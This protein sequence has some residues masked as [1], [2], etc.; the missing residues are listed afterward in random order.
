MTD[1]KID[2]WNP[3]TEAKIDEVKAFTREEVADAVERAQRAQREWVALS[4]AARQQLL[5]DIA[6]TVMRHRDE[7]A[8]LESQDVGKP[9]RAALAEA[10]SVA[11]VFRY[12]AG[13][14]DKLSGESIPVDGGVTLTFHEPVGVVG[15]I[16]PWNFPLPIASWN[17]APALA[18]GN[19]VIV[20]PASLTPLS[21]RRLGELVE[22]ISP[23]PGLLQVVTGGGGSVGSTLIEH[24]GVRKISFTG[25]TEVGRSILQSS[26][27]DFTRVTLELGGKSANI[28]FADADVKAAAQAAPWAVFD[29]SG[30]DCCARSRILVQRDALDEFLEEF[31]SA[32]DALRVGDPG[33][34]ETDL[35]PLV[36]AEHRDTVLS[37]IDDDLNLLFKGRAPEGKGHWLAPHI[38]LDESGATRA[39]REEIFGPVAVVIPFDTEQDAIRLA[40]E[41]VYGLSGSIWTGNVGRALR[42]ARGVESGTLA[43]NSNSSIRVQTPFGGFK[44]SG[45]GR[46]LGMEGLRGYTE[47][48]SVFLNG[49]S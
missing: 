45:I 33:Q 20:K 1:S 15:I 24:P 22:E 27:Q 18:A 11:G 6:D 42:V 26:A 8:Q 19:A 34:L 29:N 35:G 25:S 4:F 23:V 43:V 16:T 14:I 47:L 44:Q 7:L 30:Q 9:M 39:A 13:A 12:Y 31:V 46:E 37:F 5:Y 17:I 36:S 40:N 48:K 38:A 49:Q 2:V 28:V 32:T 3:A 21:T 41:S 10:E